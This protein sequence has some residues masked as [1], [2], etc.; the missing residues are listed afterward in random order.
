MPRPDER[1]LVIRHF[2][3]IPPPERGLEV[4]CLGEMPWVG[5]ATAIRPDESYVASAGGEVKVRLAAIR[6]VRICAL[7]PCGRGL[8]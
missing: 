7:S 2:A 6:A 1:I 8:P 3:K 5:R 4:Q